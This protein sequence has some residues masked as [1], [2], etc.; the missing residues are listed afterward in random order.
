M[1]L[2]STI[3]DRVRH[4]FPEFYRE[5]GEN[6]I[7]FV[8][9]YFEWLEM[10][11]GVVQQI[12]EIANIN[13]I[14]KTPERF[15]DNFR[16]TYMKDMP[17]ELLGNQRLFQ[18]HILDLYRSKGS[19]AG[20]KLLFRL[21]YNEDVEKYI[22]SYDI[23]MASDGTWV[24]TK[25]LEVSDVPSLS[26]FVGKYITGLRSKAHAIVEDV[27]Y[28][29]SNGKKQCVVV[30]SNISG[31]FQIDEGIVYDGLNENEAPYIYGSV[32]GFEILSSSSG[33]NAGDV[34]V[35]TSHEQKPVK[36]VIDSTY[37][38]AGSIAF[39]LIDGGTYY[40]MDAQVN[41]TAGSNTSGSGASF[42]VGSIANTFMY[43]YSTE[44]IDDYDSVLLN[45]TTFGFAGNTSANIN[46]IISTSLDIEEVEVGTISSIITTSQGK[47]YDGDV[48]VNIIDPYTVG[49]GLGGNDAVVTGIASFGN[50]FAQSL[51]VLDSGYDYRNRGTLTL[52]SINEDFR[53][54]IARPIFSGIGT[55]EGYFDD[56]K[57]FLSEDKYLADGHYYQ[58]FSYVVKSSKPLE[59]YV[60]I[61]RK[62]YHPSG[63]AVYGAVVLTSVENNAASYSSNVRVGVYESIFGTDES[64][65]V[66]IEGLNDDL[67]Y[68]TLIG[69]IQ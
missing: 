7:A 16:N 18:K 12:H 56:T 47:F 9:A 62:T 1:N 57:G 35:D 65:N 17:V 59:R 24:E 4:Q 64:G 39:K 36:V 23:F 20:L 14:D 22:P 30:V 52:Y 21:L 40:S 2:V 60:D 61:L 63:N 15:L 28:I 33:F 67:L 69:K 58:N 8:E 38:A 31:V 29:A 50:G 48:T 10:E 19:D 32:V 3:S 11:G 68:S 45:A 25:Y 6:F 55:S 49:S 54:I 37:N 26:S 53:S 5:E 34:L 44:I 46:S 51:Q 66:N 43:E 27:R 41:I 42:V 13:D